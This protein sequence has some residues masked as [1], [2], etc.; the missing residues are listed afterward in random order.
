M[1]TISDKL[2][3]L[4]NTKTAIR[5]SLINKG[6]A[7]PLNTPFRDYAAKI[8]TISAGNGLSLPSATIPSSY[9]YTGIDFPEWT[10]EFYDEVY[11]QELNSYPATYIPMP[12]P[13]KTEQV[14]Y[15]LAAVYDIPSNCAAFSAQGD[16]TVDWGD[17]IIENYLS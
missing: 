11:Q 14:C 8:N 1:G 3:Y 13:A 15:I 5:D 6:I 17:G 4:Q 9:D 7:V 16:Y 10:Q 12:E 2:L